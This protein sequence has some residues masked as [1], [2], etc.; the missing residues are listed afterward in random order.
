MDEHD[1]GTLSDVK[2]NVKEGFGR[3]T[4]DEDTA[5]EGQ[6]Q[7]AQGDA[8]RGLGDIQDAVRGDN[9]AERETR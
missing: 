2:G 6:A 4:G 1:K 7:Q 9:E 8:Q 5:A 3:L